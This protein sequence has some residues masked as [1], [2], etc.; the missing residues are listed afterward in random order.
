VTGDSTGFRNQDQV[1]FDLSKALGFS[2]ESL[3][4]NREGRLS[5]EQF[6]RHF[7]RCISPLGMAIFFAALPLLFWTGL[8][9]M[10]EHL[11]FSAALTTL[12]GKLMNI[13]QML[14]DDGKLSTIAK[15]GSIL[16]GLGFGAFQ[17][18]KFSPARYFDLLA[19]DVVTREGRVIARE[20]QTM[21]SNGR[22]PIE[23]YFFDVKTERYDVNLAAYR[24]LES[25]AMYLIY[26]LPRSGALI[27]LEPKV[28][29]PGSGSSSSPAP[30]AEAAPATEPAPPAT[31]SN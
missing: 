12:L 13:S 29:R 11:S 28:T 23:K 25:G 21:R 9:G 14:E 8:T 31:V 26:V 15:V 27:A 19:R 24:A 6:T 22:D 3:A 4:A 17:L 18:M 1:L 30:A 10:R 2:P 16:A 5:S 20:E 7:G